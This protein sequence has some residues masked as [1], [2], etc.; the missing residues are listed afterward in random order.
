MLESV[1]MRINS[2]VRDLGREKP[3]RE[4]R[5]TVCYSHWMCWA[6]EEKNCRK[7]LWEVGPCPLC[8]MLVYLL[9]SLYVFLLLLLNL[10]I[11]HDLGFL[12]C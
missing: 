8:R 7:W 3:W 6:E 4:K 2:S 11:L 9:G 12:I 10:E 1:F 5:A